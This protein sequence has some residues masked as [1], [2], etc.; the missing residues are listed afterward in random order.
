V[1]SNLFWTDQ[2]GTYGISIR[3]AV[4]TG[5]VIRNNE[6][7]IEEAGGTAIFRAGATADAMMSGNMVAGGPTNITA[8]TQTI[9]GGLYAVENYVSTNAG[10]VIIDATT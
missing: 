6:F 2:A 7:F 1:D 4:T 5:S 10:G 3:N 9:D 8:I